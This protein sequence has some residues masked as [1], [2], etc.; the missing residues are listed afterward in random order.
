LPRLQLHTRINA[1]LERCFDLARDVQAHC[2]TAAFTRERVLLPGR[3]KGLLQ[4]GDEVIFEAVH[5]GIRQRLTARITECEPPARF[6]DEMVRGPFKR[7]RHVHTFTAD[8]DATLMED[9]IEWE[10]PLGPLGRLADVLFLERHL[11]WFLTTKQA[12]LKQLA[13]QSNADEG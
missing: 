7:L 9:L 3:T 10:A 13:E 4:L 8:G 11:R 5:L 2:R 1:P 12:L 6:V